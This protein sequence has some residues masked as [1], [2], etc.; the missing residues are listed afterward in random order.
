MSEPTTHLR[1]SVNGEVVR[2]I[3]E[4]LGVSLREMATDVGISKSYLGLI[5]GGEKQPR[6]LV[7]RAIANRLGVTVNAITRFMPAPVVATDDELVDEHPAG[8]AS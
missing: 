3:R 4:A 7:V 8:A 5:E 2:A 1:R 6:D